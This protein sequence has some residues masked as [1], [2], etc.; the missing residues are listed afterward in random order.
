MKRIIITVLLGLFA[1]SL[2]QAQTEATTKH[3]KK[4]ILYD[5]G[6]WKYSETTKAKTSQISFECSDLIET[7]TDKMTGDTSIYSR[8]PLVI[9]DDGGKKG[10]LILFIKSS[11]NTIIMY[12][13]IY[14]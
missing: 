8:E 5:D 1:I 7:K 13:C 6:T 14:I 9:S 12:K 3:G 11:Y 10:F 4:V 2:L